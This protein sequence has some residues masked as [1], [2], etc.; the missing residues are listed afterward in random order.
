LLPFIT[1]LLICQLI[2]EAIARGLDLPLPGPVVGMALLFAGLLLRGGVPEGLAK[3]S[4][5]LLDHLSLL[6]VPAGVGVMLHFSLVAREW[7][8]IAGALIGSAVL[9]VAVTALVMIVFTRLAGQANGEENEQEGE[10]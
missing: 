5:G 2:G 10:R 6:F 3:T 9:T 4:G 8:P 7:L 1:L